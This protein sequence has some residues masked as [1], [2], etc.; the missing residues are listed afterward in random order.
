MVLFP[1]GNC[2]CHLR[3]LERTRTIKNFYIGIYVRP[4]LAEALKGSFKKLIGHSLVEATN[5][6]GEFFPPGTYAAFICSWRIFGNHSAKTTPS[7]LVGRIMREKPM[8][9]HIHFHIFNIII[10]EHIIIIFF[11]TVEIGPT[12]L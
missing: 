7:Y 2:R 8:L 12:A 11:T 1:F 4:I 3:K 9:H 10:S 6:N 5:N